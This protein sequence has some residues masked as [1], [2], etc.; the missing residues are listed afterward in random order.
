MSLKIWTIWR[1]VVVIQ[2][3]RRDARGH[4]AK[5]LLQRRNNSLIQRQVEGSISNLKNK[6]C[7]H[8]PVC[9]A[10]K[11]DRPCSPDARSSRTRQPVGSVKETF[12]QKEKHFSFSTVCKGHRKKVH[13]RAKRQSA[14]E[15]E[16]G[17]MCRGERLR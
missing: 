3:W 17:G 10:V 7:P 15:A 2:W 11:P 16:P 8:S 4:T 5:L 13:K 12:L 6:S 9:G 1:S 14:V